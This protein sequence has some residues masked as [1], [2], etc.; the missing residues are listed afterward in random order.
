[1]RGERL[2]EAP[3]R[4]G[5]EF[6]DRAAERRLGAFEVALLRAEPVEAFPLL[7]VGVERERVDR[8]EALQ[9]APERGQL[10]AGA[11]RL[12]IVRDLDGARHERLALPF[13]VALGEGV[14]AGLHVGEA[15]AGGVLLFG[16]G[17]VGAAGVAGGAFVRGEVGAEVEQRGLGGLGGVFEGLPGVGERGEGA[18]GGAQGGLPAAGGVFERGNRGGARLRLP[19][20]VGEGAGGAGVV[21]LQRGEARAGGAVGEAGLVEGGEHVGG[22]LLVRG[23][24]ALGLGA[25]GGGGGH[26]GIGGGEGGVE[27]REG[28]VEGFGLVLERSGTDAAGL[29]GSSAGLRLRIGL[30]LRGFGAA[31]RTGGLVARAAEGGAVV[32][33]AAG[34][35][36]V[37]GGAEGGVFGLSGLQFGTKD[38]EARAEGEAR[39]GGFGRAGGAAV[40]R[41]P[42]GPAALRGHEAQTG[43]GGGEHLRGGQ[44]RGEED[45]R[46]ERAGKRG[47]RRRGG[48][49]VR[50][51]GDGAGRRGWG[52]RRASA[53]EGDDGGLAF[54]GGPERGQGG[55][56]FGARGGEGPRAARPEGGAQGSGVGVVGG[57]H[58]RHGEQFARRP[59]VV[60]GE[61][62]EGAVEVFAGAE[63]A[64]EEG[65]LAGERAPA[66]VEGAARFGEGGGGGFHGGALGFGGVKRGLGGV[67]GSEGSGDGGGPLRSFGPPPPV[68]GEGAVWGWG[69]RGGLG[70]GA[71]GFGA[72]EVEAGGVAVEGAGGLGAAG[73]GVG[74]GA[75]GGGSGGAG[76]FDGALRVVAG[77]AGGVEGSFSGLGVG[78]GAGAFGAE[79]LVGRRHGGAA[80]G[81]L[82]LLAARAVE[83]GVGAREALGGQAALGVGVFGAREVALERSLRVGAGGLARGE[84]EVQGLAV[85]VEGALAR[86]EGGEVFGEAGER[87]LERL[88]LGV[89]AGVF[90]VGEKLFERTAAGVEVAEAGGLLG[91]PLERAH[92]GVEFADE[93][94]QARQ[95]GLRAVELGERLPAAQ[96][97]AR[98][99][100]G[101]LEEAAAVVAV[102]GEDLL[103]HRQLD[104]R[105]GAGAHAGVHEQVLHVAQAAGWLLSRY[106]DSPER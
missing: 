51:E 37:E 28:G 13:G 29:G 75:A 86:R 67:Q 7:L 8:A 62:A 10:S 31:E 33:G 93:V 41:G 104:D 76:G 11:R 97:E 1:M 91:L 49:D 45:A 105:V 55:V 65:G 79:P 56:G 54:G 52:I 95:V 71:G 38:V 70:E 15:D 32:G 40:E 98:H 82:G 59:G 73:Q 6:A 61:K 4:L 81:A 78:D 39:G 60:G 21:G 72:G 36:R 96:L 19:V 84:G 106:S 66:G 46:E 85:G 87:A 44:V 20:E 43:M 27:R 94:A 80:G 64:V 22:A 101:F 68:S 3:R 9:A 69:G 16:A 53:V 90:G 47:K 14:A 63:Q 18:F 17:G 42:F 100:R 74:L 35:E 48:P 88:G 30:G 103:H 24:R 5:V 2:L 26:G 89:E 99:A 83:V 77:G 57:E 102:L 12:E 25:R 34:L 50:G 58:V 23:E 92:A